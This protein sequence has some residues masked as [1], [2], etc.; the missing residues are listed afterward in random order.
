MNSW[1]RMAHSLIWK[2]ARLRKRSKSE[3]QLERLIRRHGKYATVKDVVARKVK[4]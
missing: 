1:E 2:P 3:M 4:S